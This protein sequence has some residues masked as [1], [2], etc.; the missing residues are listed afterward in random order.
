MD[1][2]VSILEPEE[3]IIY[4]DVDEHGNV[5]YSQGGTNP[6]PEKEYKFFFIRDVQTLENILKFKVVI[7]GYTPKLVLKDGE[8]LDEV[9]DTPSPTL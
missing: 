4:V 8:V 2:E 7:D 1:K 9:V 6:K 3:I 5:T